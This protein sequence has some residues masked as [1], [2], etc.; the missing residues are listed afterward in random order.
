MPVVLMSSS[1][2]TTVSAAASTSL[3]NFPHLAAKVADEGTPVLNQQ[4]STAANGS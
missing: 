4:M 3:K 2:K 1:S